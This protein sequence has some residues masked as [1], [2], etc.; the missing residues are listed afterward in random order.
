[1]SVYCNVYMYVQLYVSVS[2]K[3][4]HDHPFFENERPCIKTCVRRHNEAD[5]YVRRDD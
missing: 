3:Y 5:M 2:H 4:V 1:M